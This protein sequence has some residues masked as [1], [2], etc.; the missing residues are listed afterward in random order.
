MF[1]RAYLGVGVSKKADGI[2]LTPAGP[3]ND[4]LWSM[5]RLLV[6]YSGGDAYW[7]ESSAF[8]FGH[9]PMGPV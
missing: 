4:Q 9:V 7:R 3:S 1:E 8:G 6:H 5:G 2:E